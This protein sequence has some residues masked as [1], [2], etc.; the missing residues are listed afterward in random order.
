MIWT[1]DKRGV[2]GANGAVPWHRPEQQPELEAVTAGHGVI[3]GRRTWDAMTAVAPIVSERPVFVISRDDSL[4]IP[5]A[6]VA[7]SLDAALEGLLSRGDDEVWILGGG[8][9]FSEGVGQADVAIV[10]SIDHSYNGD[11][12]APGLGSEW[13]AADPETPVEWTTSAGGMRY[14]TRTYRKS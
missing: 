9:I 8:Q 6:V 12:Y 10:T 1:Q 14:R 3:V 4:V 7:R 13:S 2:I 11:T 5:G